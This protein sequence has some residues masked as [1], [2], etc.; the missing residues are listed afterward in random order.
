MESAD[1]NQ[2]N[3]LV[4][5]LPPQSRKVLSETLSK[6]DEFLAYNDT[7]IRDEIA[8]HS[9]SQSMFCLPISLLV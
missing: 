1:P 8:G 7:L 5:F 9:Q 2:I 3:A 6:V 4:W